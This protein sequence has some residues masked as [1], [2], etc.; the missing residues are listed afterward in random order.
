[1]FAQGF[2]EKFLTGLP[3]DVREDVLKE[4]EVS[5]SSTEGSTV[6]ERRPISKLKLEESQSERYG[7]DFFNSVQSSFMPINDPNINGDYIL[8]F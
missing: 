6:I 5:Q 7:I 8:D 4:L 1:L 2:D 3:K